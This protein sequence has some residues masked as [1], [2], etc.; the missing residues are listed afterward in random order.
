MLN[1]VIIKVS[2]KFFGGIHY[3]IRDNRMDTQWYLLNNF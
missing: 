3:D 2:K 1:Y